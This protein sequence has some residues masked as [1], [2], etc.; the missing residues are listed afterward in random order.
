M[1]PIFVIII[2]YLSGFV[3]G[4][5]VTLA[6]TSDVWAFDPNR[7]PPAYQH[8]PPVQKASPW[9]PWQDPLVIIGRPGLAPVAPG[10]AV[11]CTT[12]FNTWSNRWTTTCR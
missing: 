4:V 3:L 11:R 9:K 10:Q 8:A 7:W 1:R 5:L 6:W 12:F 2:L